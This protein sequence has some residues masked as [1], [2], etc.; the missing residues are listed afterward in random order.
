MLCVDRSGQRI[1]FAKVRMGREKA[2]EFRKELEVMQ[3]DSTRIEGFKRPDLIGGRELDDASVLLTEVLPD[4][5]E[6]VEWRAVIELLRATRA[7]TSTGRLGSFTWWE[8]ATKDP[9]LTPIRDELVAAS[10]E[11]IGCGIAHGDVRPSNVAL[12]KGQHWLLDW[13]TFVD[14]APWASDLVMAAAVASFE[15]RRRRIHRRPFSVRGLDRIDVLAATAFLSQHNQPQVSKEL[16][17]WLAVTTGDVVAF[18]P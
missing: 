7:P 2:G 10:M 8:R 15:R 17:E 9:L 1:A 18:G 3:S 14:G 11:E 4:A 6:P 16:I 13:E 12:V 5:R